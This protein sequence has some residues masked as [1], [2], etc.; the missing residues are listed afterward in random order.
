[1]IAAF[2]HTDGNPRPEPAPVKSPS[3]F[4]R[5][6]N[7][8]DWNARAIIRTIRTAILSQLWAVCAKR[9]GRRPILEIIEDG[10]SL[11]KPEHS[12]TSSF[13]NPTTRSAWHLVVLYVLVGVHRF[14][15]SPSAWRDKPAISPIQLA[16][17]L[18]AQL[19]RWWLYSVHCAR[20][21]RQRV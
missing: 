3:A 8:Y 17:R 6:V 12:P 2:L 13:I 19:P 10:T 20:P 1:V 16:L 4:S 7:R 15:W 5:F 21:G 11:E 9:K 18:L 14:P